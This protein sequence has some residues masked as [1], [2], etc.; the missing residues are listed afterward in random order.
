MIRMRKS[1]RY[2]WVKSDCSVVFALVVPSSCW[3]LRFAAS[4][5]S[6]FF[7]N[8]EC[9]LMLGK[10]YSSLIRIYFY[11]IKTLFRASLEF[12][13]KNGCFFFYISTFRRC[14]KNLYVRTEGTSLSIISRF[15]L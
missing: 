1:I 2:K 4:L 3:Y 13:P 7:D 14:E 10:E 6:L 8:L 15:T 11:R 9:L 5:E 12:G